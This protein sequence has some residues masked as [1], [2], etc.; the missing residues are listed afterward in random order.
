M[1]NEWDDMEDG[2]D[3][4]SNMKMVES[5]LCAQHSSIG[6]RWKAYKWFYT[7][8]GIFLF[9]LQAKVEWVR[10]TSYIQCVFFYCSNVNDDN[11]KN[12]WNF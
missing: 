6:R 3:K 9:I 8:S 1:Y 10:C 7:Y 5:V 11:R 4:E 2:T 12:L